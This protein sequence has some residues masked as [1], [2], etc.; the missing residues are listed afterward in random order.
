MTRVSV[1]DY[2]QEGIHGK[3]EIKPEER[4]KYLGTLRERVVAVLTQAQV[5]EKTIYPE[6]ERLLKENPHATLLLNG[7]L[8]Y[9]DIRKYIAL[10]NENKTAYKIVA[11]SNHVTELGLVL[12]CDTAIDKATITVDSRPQKAVEKEK[13]PSLFSKIIRRIKL[14]R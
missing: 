2:L 12:A 7:S 8:N 13:K 11:N 14:K 3:K 9:S 4:R 10:A 1:D 6:I 5:R